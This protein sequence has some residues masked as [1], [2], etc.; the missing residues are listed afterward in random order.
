[1]NKTQ[2]DGKYDGL[3][4]YL[5]EGQTMKDITNMSMDILYNIYHKDTLLTQKVEQIE[6][7]VFIIYYVFPTYSKMIL[8]L[9][10]VSMLQMHE[11][12][13]EGLYCCFGKVLKDK[14][15]PIEYN[16]DSYIKD[17]LHVIYFKENLRF[18]KL[19]KANKEVYLVFSVKNIGHKKIA[20][21][22][23]SGIVGIDGFVIGEIE[24][25]IEKSN[26]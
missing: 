25:L 9:P 4:T 23:Y 10:H 20:K 3:L 24:C 16:Y 5:V 21:S 2:F 22:F 18:T 13:L 14:I 12:L 6:D 11:A 26:K 8:K 19:I 7:K 15:F 1:M 17:S